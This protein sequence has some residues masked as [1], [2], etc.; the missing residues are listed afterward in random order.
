M[1]NT[2]CDLEELSL[3]FPMCCPPGGITLDTTHPHLK[4]FSFTG[5]ALLQESDFL[6]QHPGLESLFLDTEQRFR[7]G[8][9]A[10]SPHTLRAL[11]VDDLSLSF[12]PTL[13]DFQITHLRLRE[14]PESIDSSVLD[15]VHAMRTLRC[16]E[17]D[18]YGS[19]HIPLPPHAISFLQSALVLDELGIIRCGKMPLSPGWSA[20]ML[21]RLS[22]SFMPRALTVS[23]TDL[24]HRSHRSHRTP[25]SI[26]L[27][28]WRRPSA[29]TAS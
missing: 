22:G 28:L 8:T 29:S 12:S 19:C 13:F 1:L 9:D 10:S 16:L 4:R 14:F 3:Q 5:A 23:T 7:S 26:A 2:L 21:V 18:I 6:V 27:S 20:D 11:N 15:A 24:R 17:L 25:A